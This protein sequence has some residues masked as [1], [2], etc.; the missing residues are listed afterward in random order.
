M[1]HGLGHGWVRSWIRSKWIP[2]GDEQHLTFDRAHRHE[3][4]MIFYYDLMKVDDDVVM[5]D[6]HDNRRRRL[7]MLV[8]CIRG[9]ASLAKQKTVDFSLSQ[10]PERFRTLLAHAFAQRWEGLVLKPSREPYFSTKRTSRG[11]PAHCWIKLKKDYIPGLGDTVDFAVIGAGYNAARAAQLKDTSLKFTHFHIG[12]LKNKE[13][14]ISM[15][16]KPHFVVVAALEVNLEMAKHLNQHGQFSASPFGS[17]ASYNDPFE[18]VLARGVPTMIVVFRKPFVFDVMGAGFEKEP[19]RD[20]YTLRFPRVLKIHDDRDWKEA[21]G[22]DELQGMAKVARTVPQSMNTCVAGWMRQL[23]QVDRGAKGSAVPWDLSDD[24]VETPQDIGPKQFATQTTPSRSTR[25]P[26]EAPPL[27]RMDTQEMTDRE[28]RLDCGEVVHRPLSQHSHVTNWSESNLPTPPKSSQ[29]GDVHI[30]NHREPLSS[31]QS[32]NS[33]DRRR[34][35]STNEGEECSEERFPKN[36]RMS[37]P[38]I[39]INQPAGPRTRTH[40]RASSKRPQSH[41]NTA[42]SPP[43]TSTLDLSRQA[44]E[45]PPSK[46]F[47]LPKLSAGAAEALHFRAKTQVIR[48]MEP[49]SPDRQTTADERSSGE[50]QSTQQSLI[51]EW[52]LSNAEQ[53]SQQE[54]NVPDLHDSYIVLSPD[55]SGMPYLTEDLLAT[56]GLA[57]RPARQVFGNDSN[58]NRSRQPTSYHDEGKLQDVVVLIEGRR[59]DS[60]LNMLKFL[61]GRVPTDGSQ[62]FWVFDWRLVEDMFARGVDEDERLLRK[63]LIARFW[64]DEDKEMSWLSSSGEVMLIPQKNIEESKGLS[65]AFLGGA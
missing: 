52:Q 2:T 14:V 4:L 29:P 46:T 50:N 47:L 28:I 11:L 25:R 45:D 32:T 27:I 54:F 60:S 10:A 12:C 9:R 37:P 65:R 6:S 26:S 40:Q 36:P 63:R 42:P 33:T 51:S 58:S 22:F 57:S 20:D 13:Q 41:K 7:E 61:I 18:I 34:K 3:H 35:R 62:V 64:Y 53:S 59:H 30:A 23:E 16:A 5:N 39:E 19:N 1:F 44:V 43:P 38:T 56:E 55:V 17:L 15:N 24:D 8:T 21:L 31:I 49:T 48:N